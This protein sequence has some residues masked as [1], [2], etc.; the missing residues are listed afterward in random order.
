MLKTL[1][2]QVCRESSVEILLASYFQLLQ[3]HLSAHSGQLFRC[4]GPPLNP[5]LITIVPTKNVNLDGSLLCIYVTATANEYGALMEWGT[6]TAV[7]FRETNARVTLSTAW[8]TGTELRANPGLRREKL[9]TNRPGPFSWLQLGIKWVL[10]CDAHKLFSE[11]RVTW[12]WFM[13]Y[14][15]QCFSTAGPRS[16][17]GPW[18]Q[19]YRAARGLRKLQYATGFH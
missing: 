1:A 16:G 19:L 7:V 10:S 15:E 8:S 13:G 2:C 11:R 6:E 4:A 17:T 14:L 12:F 5:S 3:W 18:H 9:A